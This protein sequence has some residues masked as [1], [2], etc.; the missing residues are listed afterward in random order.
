MYH[1]F[2][3]PGPAPSATCATKVDLCLIIDSSGSIRDNN[4]TDRSYDNWDLQLRFL[5]ELVASFSVGFDETRIGAIVFSEQVRLVFALDTYNSVSDVQQAIRSIAYMGQT[6]N[7]PE[8]L[9]QTRMQCFNRATGDRPD[10]A[11]VAIIVTDGVPYP[12]NRRNPAIDEAAAL[13]DAGVTMIAVGVTDVI[14][15][16]FLRAM[17]SP[18]QIEGENFFTATDFTE[19][20]DITKTVVEGT[21]QTVVVGMLKFSLLFF[22]LIHSLVTTNSL[23]MELRIAISYLLTV[24]VLINT[25]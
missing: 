13:R 20:E 25:S 8:G 1:V 2:V 11:N 21:C 10:V 15:Q 23:Q 12:S 19:L 16:A 3:E 4:P 7:T 6:T 14:D 17:S 18:P 5:S 24:K 22:V 9:L